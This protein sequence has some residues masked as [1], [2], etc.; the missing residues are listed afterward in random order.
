M[1]KVYN[2]AVYRKYDKTAC[3]TYH[4]Q[5]NMRRFHKWFLENYQKYDWWYYNVYERL[6]EK[7]TVFKVRYYNNTP[8]NFVKFTP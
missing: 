4:K 1:A 8:L 5:T 7:Q 2:I 3:V 6:P